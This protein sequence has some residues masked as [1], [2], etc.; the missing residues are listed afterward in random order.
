MSFLSEIVRNY[1]FRTGEFTTKFIG[2]EY[3]KGFKGVELTEEEVKNVTS[4]AY[5]YDLIKR[6]SDSGLNR[7]DWAYTYD[8]HNP[9]FE[10]DVITV[11]GTTTKQHK[12]THIH[13]KEFVETTEE[14]A[15]EEEE[16]PPTYIRAKLSNGERSVV[17]MLT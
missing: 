4:V 11:H 6:G 16:L 5:L 17:A 8:V 10:D 2:Q 13:F 9:D 3:P 14:E 12:M 7:D 15:E 1:R